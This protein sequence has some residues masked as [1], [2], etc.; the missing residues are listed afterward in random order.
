MA[1]LNCPAD[2]AR[3]AGRVL[4]RLAVLRA[5]VAVVRAPKPEHVHVDRPRRRRGVRLQRGR[6]DRARPLPRRLSDARRRRDL[7]RYDGRDHRCSCCSDRCWSCAR[8]TVP[9]RRFASCSGWRRRPRGSFATAA[10]RMCRSATCS[11][12]DILRVRPGD[13]IPVDG[14]VVEGAASIDESMVT[15]EPIPVGSGG[16]RSRDRRDDRRPTGR[17]LMRAERVGADTLLAQIVRMVGEAQRT[18]APIQRLADRVAAYLRAGG[19]AVGD[20][21]V[22]GVERL[23]A[24]TAIRSRRCV[25]AVAVL[26]IACPCALGLATPMAIMVG[27]GEGAQSGVLIKNAEALELLGRVDTLV[28][29]KTGTLTEGRPRRDRGRAASG[30]TERRA[31]ATRPRRSSAAASIRS[32]ARSSAP[33]TSAAFAIPA[34]SRFRVGHRQGRGRPRRWP[35][36]RSRQ[37]RADERARHRSPTPLLERAE[38]AAPRRADGRCSS[39]SMAALAGLI[40]VADPIRAS[41]RRGGAPAAGRGA[42]TW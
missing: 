25:N 5:H 7:L 21:D 33:P 40:A 30:V 4:V 13:K 20:A 35:S 19:R 1:Q 16:R 17:S 26:I 18:R 10:K 14:V 36:R 29:D 9:A 31:A 27:T 3:D 38:D 12:G 42:A 15:G 24:R 28:V 22:R 34:A 32:P 37:R 6:D 39:P 8:A 41:T 23:G 11:L 2:D